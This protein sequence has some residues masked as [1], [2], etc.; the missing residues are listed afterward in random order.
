VLER[1]KAQ[2]RAEAINAMNTP[3]FE[4]PNSNFGNPNFGRITRQANF[5]RFIQFGLRFFWQASMRL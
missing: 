4:A 1:F 3:L 5:P 2:F